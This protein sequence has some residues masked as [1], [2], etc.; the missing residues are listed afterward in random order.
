MSIP[1]AAEPIAHIA[2]LTVTN[3]LINAWIA[4]IILIIAAAAIRFGARQRPGKFQSAVEMLFEFFLKTFDSVT[5]DRVRT[6][7]FF[8][9]VTTLFLFILISNWLGQLPGT[10]TF[11]IW[12]M[13]HGELELVPL[14]RPATSDLNLT[15]GLGIFAIL[16]THVMGIGAL[17]FFRHAGKFIQI[18]KLFTS[19]NKGPIAMLTAIIDFGAGLIE[20]VG[21]FARAISLSLRLFGNVF[22]GEVLITVMLGLAAFVIPLPF[23]ALELLVGVIQATVFSV[24]TLVFLTLA[25]EPPHG[26][27]AEEHATAEH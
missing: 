10:G 21:E 7:K 13:V 2:G 25:T 14:L 9:V 27:H 6:R 17:G 22:A 15:L 12:E 18:R 19:F 23:Q 24:L 16:L 3:S 4:A 8:P 20:A 1:L 5:H 11:G 26:E